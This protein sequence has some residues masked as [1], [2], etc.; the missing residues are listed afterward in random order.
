MLL[1]CSSYESTK[2][3]LAN[4]FNTTEERLVSALKALRPF[5]SV[6]QPPEDILYDNVCGIFGAPRDDISILWFHGTR[7]DNEK[8]FY[9]HGILNKS[10]ARKHIEPRLIAMSKGLKSSGCNPFS[11]S[12]SGKQ[13]VH[14]EGPFAFL[15]REVAIQAPVPY[16]NY[17]DAPEM[18]EDIAGT[19]LGENYLQLVDRFKE[20]TSPCV[21]SFTSE[22]KGD[23][24][25]CA[26]LYLKFIEDGD[27]D[28]EAASSANTFF[29]SEGVVVSPNRI[30][31]VEFISNV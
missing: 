4:I 12:L 15:I 28:I 6:C 9:E 25:P 1:D 30:Q 3:S 26:L 16:H 31:S 27:I 22:S 21:V 18:V 24:L 8:L 10:K 13:G 19:L 14:D 7:T 5:E 23:E 20:I 11:V 29:D 17:L 2:I